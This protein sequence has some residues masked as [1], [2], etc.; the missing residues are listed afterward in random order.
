MAGGV[1]TKKTNGEAAIKDFVFGCIRKIVSNVKGPILSRYSD[2]KENFVGDFSLRRLYERTGG[3]V[4][5]SRCVCARF[6]S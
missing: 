6:G 3:R 4:A 1:L 2:I 5:S